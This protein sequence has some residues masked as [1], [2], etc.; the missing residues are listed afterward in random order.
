MTTVYGEPNPQNVWN[1][2]PDQ[3]HYEVADWALSGNIFSGVVDTLWYM[4]P[5]SVNAPNIF[6][7]TERE[8]NSTE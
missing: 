6:P 7:I 1:T 3:M 4:N 2:P 8:F 5:Y